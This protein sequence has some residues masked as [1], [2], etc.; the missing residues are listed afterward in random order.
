MEAFPKFAAKNVKEDD[1]M[2]LCRGIVRPVLK[3][4]AKEEGKRVK[5]DTLPKTA[6]PVAGYS[7]GVNDNLHVFH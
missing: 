7:F 4:K 5:S 6:M 3:S 2:N 1:T